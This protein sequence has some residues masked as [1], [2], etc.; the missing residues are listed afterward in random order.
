MIF[1]LRNLA[2]CF[3]N[4]FSKFSLWQLPFFASK[5]WTILSKWKQYA[6]WNSSIKLHFSF[7][8]VCCFLVY[9]IHFE[10]RFHLLLTKFNKSW[11][12]LGWLQMNYLLIFETRYVDCFLWLHLLLLYFTSATLVWFS[13]FYSGMVGS[14]LY[15]ISMLK[16]V[17]TIPL[18]I[19]RLDFQK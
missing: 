11:I 4:R 15:F 6:K 7:Y 10:N 16:L 18:Q 3:S 14:I 8:F 12:C 19:S 13:L 5:K 9:L 1:F 17:I 2:V